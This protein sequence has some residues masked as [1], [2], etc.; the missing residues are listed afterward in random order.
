MKNHV[1]VRQNKKCMRP[2]S[3]K[4]QLSH[5]QK[6]VLKWS[7][8]NHVKD[9]EGRE[10]ASYQPSSILESVLRT[11]LSWVQ[12]DSCCFDP[13]LTPKWMRPMSK[14]TTSWG[15]QIPCGRIN[16]PETQLACAEQLVT[17]SHIGGHPA[18]LRWGGFIWGHHKVDE[19]FPV[20]KKEKE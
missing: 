9:S 6:P 15:A 16:N 12:L 19:S 2:M 10:G 5:N 8:Q 4:K 20:V 13:P 11:W 1:P 7:T 3:T 17:M 14:N 18:W